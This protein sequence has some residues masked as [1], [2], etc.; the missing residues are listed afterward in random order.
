MS[1]INN[2]LDRNVGRQP[3]AT[4]L[5]EAIRMSKYPLVCELNNHSRKGVDYLESIVVN[6]LYY[7]FSYL[8][9]L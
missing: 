7:V 9:L 2:F 6:T 1:Y 4:G 8:E 3:F 5:H